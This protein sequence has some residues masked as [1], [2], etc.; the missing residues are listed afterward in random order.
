MTTTNNRAWKAL[1]PQNGMI[2]MSPQVGRVK[3]PP[4]RVRQTLQFP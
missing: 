4:I 1:L 3:I 2:G